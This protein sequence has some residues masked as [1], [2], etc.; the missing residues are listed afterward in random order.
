MPMI[1]GLKMLAACV[2][3]SFFTMGFFAVRERS[4]HC[5]FAVVYAFYAMILLCW[6]WPYALL[7]SHKSVWMTRNKQAVPGQR[8]PLPP[9]ER[10]DPLDL[11]AVE[12]AIP[13]FMPAYAEAAA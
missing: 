13:Q 2:L 9:R 12:P 6:V 11:P 1:F 7:T 5:V 8:R 3:G 10:L 4:T